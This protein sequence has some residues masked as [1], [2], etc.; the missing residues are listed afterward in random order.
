MGK[1]AKET[2]KIYLSGKCGYIK[3]GQNQPQG[4]RMPILPSVQSFL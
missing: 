3:E 4:D 2:P 1:L